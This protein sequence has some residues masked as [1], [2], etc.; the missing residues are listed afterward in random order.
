MK[1]EEFVRLF[2]KP[3][4]Y[5]SPAFLAYYKENEAKR[6]RIG[7]TIKGRLKSVHRMRIKRIVREWF[8]GIKD[9]FGNQDVNIVV[10]VPTEID[11]VFFT[12]LAEQLQKWK[13]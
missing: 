8:R 10:K 5:K 7:I 12:R 13:V 2:D 3:K 9:R 6:A 4:S 11:H 1:R